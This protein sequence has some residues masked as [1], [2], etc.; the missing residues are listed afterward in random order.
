[1]D[2]YIIIEAQITGNSTAVLHTVKTGYFAAEQEYHTKLAYAAASSVDIHSVTMLT[3]NGRM[4]KYE[5]YD[6]R[7]P[8]EDGEEA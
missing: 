7:T 4:V 8:V 3:A 1:M 2:T 5:A 6:H